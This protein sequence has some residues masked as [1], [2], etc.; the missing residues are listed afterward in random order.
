MF[1][2]AIVLVP[3]GFDEHPNAHFPLMIF[4]DHFVAGF[5]DFRTTPP[6]PSLKPDYSQRFHSGRLQPHSAG[7]GLQVLSAMDFA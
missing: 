2:S 7:R 1:V 6:D 3:E 4:H 5:D